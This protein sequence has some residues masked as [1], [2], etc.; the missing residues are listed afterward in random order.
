MGYRPPGLRRR[1]PV[2]ASHSHGT[3]ARYS[4]GLSCP[5]SPVMSER[6]S[7]QRRLRRL[8]RIGDVVEIGTPKG[9]AYAQLYSRPSDARRAGPPLPGLYATR[10]ADLAALVRQRERY[11]TFS[12]LR[13][14]WLRDNEVIN[15]G[16]REVPEAAIVGPFLIPERNRPIPLFRAL[17]GPGRHP[18]TGKLNTWRFVDEERLWRVE[19]L[20]AA[21]RELPVEGI[22]SRP[23]FIEQIVSGW[24]PRDDVPHVVHFPSAMAAQVA[25]R[26]LDEQG[27]RGTSVYQ[28]SSVSWVV[29]AYGD[30]PPPAGLVAAIVAQPHAKLAEE[31]AG[32]E[33]AA[34]AV[35]RTAEPS[36]SH[37]RNTSCI[38]PPPRRAQEASRRLRAEG[39]KRVAVRPPDSAYFED[40]DAPPGPTAWIASGRWWPPA[41]YHRQAILSSDTRA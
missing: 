7:R 26:R 16:G 33:R 35:Q 21:Q 39:F 38:S 30:R 24:H 34:A 22:P 28:E 17:G 37:R 15:V 14:D 23:L 6:R 11:V 10:P 2:R 40:E 29:V 31:L 3:G 32:A 36:W 12:M 4:Q 27:Y 5:R 8:A 19:G 1:R 18:V 25:A 13:A 9:F 41:L 20:T